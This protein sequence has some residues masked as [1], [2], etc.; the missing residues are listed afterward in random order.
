MNKRVLYFS[1]EIL[2]YDTEDI[3]C[4]IGIE[5]KKIS[6]TVDE[7]LQRGN[8]FERIQN[9]LINDRY[10]CVFTYDYF[11]NISEICCK[12][13]VKYIIW[14]YDCPCNI[15]YSKSVANKCNYFFLFDMSMSKV[16][17]D[18][19]AKNIFDM[20]LSLNTGRINKLLGVE[21][22][23]T[24][25]K[26]D[27]SF[28][29][30]MYEDNSF[31]EICY[32]PSYV[33]GYIKGIISAQRKVW[34]IDLVDA[35]LSENIVSI[36]NRFIKL[37]DD[38][39]I[40]IPDK[41]VYS[42]IIKEKISS[43]ERIDIVNRL[44]EKFEMNLFSASDSTLCPKCHYRG[45]ADYI[46]EMPFIFRKSKININITIRSIKRGIPLRCIDIMGAGGFLLS[47]YQSDLCKYFEP[48]IDFVLYDDEDDI[49]EKVDYYLKNGDERR[50][51]ALNVWKK[52]QKYFRSDERFKEIFSKFSL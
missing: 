46:N 5:Y 15:L 42:E 22:L 33:N 26:Y 31:D 24:D 3:F 9:E 52:I 7:V 21:I 8:A 25:Y 23:N 10:D 36:L 4:Q 39:E 27:V 28:L 44:S 6:G 1:W 18:K 41:V 29:G 2:S 14:I 45:Y 50:N 51:I 17:R 11:P 38:L 16:L 43:M 30:S 37:N 12:Y 35:L 19:G 49:V 13:G 47:N 20:P 48:G 40:L 32:L 34:G